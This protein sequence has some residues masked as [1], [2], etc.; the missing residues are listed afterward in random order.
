MA[1]VL[2]ININS[3]KNP[4]QWVDLY[5][6]CPPPRFLAENSFMYTLL[7]VPRTKAGPPLFRSLYNYRRNNFLIFYPQEIHTGGKPAYMKLYSALF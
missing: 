6:C 1:A 2:L 7:R 3:I 4:D 5:S